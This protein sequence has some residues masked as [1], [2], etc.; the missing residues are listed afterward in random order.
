MLKDPDHNVFFMGFR[1]GHCLYDESLNYSFTDPTY[2]NTPIAISST[3]I[4]GHWLE[5]TTGLKV[6]ILAGFWLG[7]TARLK[8]APHAL[9]DSAQK[10]FDIPGYGIAEKAPWWGINYQAFWRIPFR[11]PEGI[12]KP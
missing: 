4:S 2:G 12:S 6:K 3:G 7:C 1:Y 5:L 9:S 11:K 10:P 8:F